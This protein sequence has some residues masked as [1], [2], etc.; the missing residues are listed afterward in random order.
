MT[1]IP[2]LKDKVQAKFRYTQSHVCN[3]PQA[4]T[5][6]LLSALPPAQEDTRSRERAL[7]NLQRK[8]LKLGARLVDLASDVQVHRLVA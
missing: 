2:S 1:N 5:D 7:R 4:G 3:C 8:A 6:Y